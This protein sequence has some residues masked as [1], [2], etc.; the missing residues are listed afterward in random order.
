MN[1][2][3]VQG[4]RLQPESPWD[5]SLSI[6]ASDDQAQQRGGSW[7]NQI[8]DGTRQIL[9]PGV[10]HRGGLRE[11]AAGIELAAPS[12]F[13]D[14]PFMEMRRE[15]D[16]TGVDLAGTVKLGQAAFPRPPGMPSIFGTGLYKAQV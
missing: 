10:K 8:G 13:W 15:S 1:F 6:Y 11:G 4:T 7:Q 12:T 3:K 14:K 16:S 2:K 9:A 5:V